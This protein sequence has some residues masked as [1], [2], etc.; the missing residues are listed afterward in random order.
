MKWKVVHSPTPAEREAGFQIN[1]FVSTG[2]PADLGSDTFIDGYR[3]DI[4]A[5]IV[6]G[7]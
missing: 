1:L 7:K 3:L 4:D 6:T 5:A 2:T